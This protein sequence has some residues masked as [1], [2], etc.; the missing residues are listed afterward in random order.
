MN[1]KALVPTRPITKVWKI[2]RQSP[3]L[4]KSSWVGL[5]RGSTGRLFHSRPVM[6]QAIP[7][8]A[9]IGKF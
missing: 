7:A 9:Q 4:M 1:I 6:V 3:A 8:H 5:G 2:F